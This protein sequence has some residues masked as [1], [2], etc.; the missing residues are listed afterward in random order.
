M[1]SIAPYDADEH[2]ENYQA[3]MLIQNANEAAFCKAFCLTLTSTA[4]Q[5]YRRLVPGS[6]GSFK[7]LV[8]AFAVAFLGAK[9]WKMETSFLFRIK[10][11]ESEP[12]KE[13]LVQSY[14]DDTLI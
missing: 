1:P 3:H 9:I 12:L 14:F 4:R 13:Y 7:Q 8:D 10:Q 11:G 6:V 2:F 5:W